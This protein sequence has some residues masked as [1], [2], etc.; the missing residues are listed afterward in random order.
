[1]N[2]QR[3][4]KTIHYCW[5]GGKPLP[6]MAL[7][8]IES[9]KKH[10]PNYEIIE[11]SEKNYDL[12]SNQFVQEAYKQ[13]KYAFV[14]DY[15]RLDV[16]NRFGGVYMDTDVE[17]LKSL[18]E[19]LQLQAFSGFETE[20]L[21]PT[22]IMASEKNGEWVKEM[23]S[24]YDQRPFILNGGKLD[25]KTNVLIISEQMAA[26]G[27]ELKNSLQEYKNCATFFPKDVFCPKNPNGKLELTPNSVCI[28]HFNGSWLTSKQKIKRYVITH[29]I[30]QN[31]ANYIKKNAIV[32]L[33]KILGKR[34]HVRPSYIFSGPDLKL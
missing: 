12:K 31:K 17:V 4:P 32:W 19:F 11:W 34:N 33:Q 24:Y 22:G 26:N 1:M 20:N 8:C 14:T 9:W 18:D 30:G 7:Q 29:L 15:V 25:T 27:F 16:L 5:F 6:K 21:V 10:L 28:H 3:I 23:I 2:L 13:K